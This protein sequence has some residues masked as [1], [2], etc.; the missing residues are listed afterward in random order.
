VWDF[1]SGALLYSITLGS[2]CF[3]ILPY[4]TD[5]GGM[6][7][8]VGSNGA[9]Y[10]V[11]VIDH[12]KRRLVARFPQL[13]R[14]TITNIFEFSLPDKPVCV[15]T[16]KDGTI[17]TWDKGD[18]RLLETF[19]SEGKSCSWCA[20]PYLNSDGRARLVYGDDK[21]GLFVYDVAGLWC[22]ISNQEGDTSVLSLDT[23]TT[24]EGGEDRLVVGTRQ[25]AVWLYTLPGLVL[26]RVLEHTRH[27]IRGLHVFDAPSDGRCLV[28]AA[29]VE[30]KVTIVDT[31]EYRAPRAGGPSHLRSAVKT[32]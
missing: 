31:G 26:L 11:R 32:G 24:A 16:S 28:A 21:G 30:R 1:S 18:Y 10:D 22:V 29:S 19:E 8:L 5:D 3:S 27:A 9:P 23:Y 7:I 6:R 13:H 2:G 20:V 15:T 17:K 25:G 4:L 12:A 14:E